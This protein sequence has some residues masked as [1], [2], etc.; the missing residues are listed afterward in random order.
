[1]GRLPISQGGLKGHAHNDELSFELCVDG[2][3]V[4][5]DP[6]TYVYTRSPE[7]R[8]R[9]RSTAFHNT[10]TI[11]SQGDDYP[12]TQADL[13]K[14]ARPVRSVSVQWHDSDEK[15]VFINEVSSSKLLNEVAMH[16]RE[17]V[18]MKMSRNG[19]LGT[20]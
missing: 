6:G 12:I 14:T 13:F 9:F 17:I 3:D 15:T 16:C 11:D 2:E 8:A 1:M 10:V 19:L 20:V 4:V 5:V 7:W 18:H